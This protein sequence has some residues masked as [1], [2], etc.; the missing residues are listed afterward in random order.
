[1]KL[2]LVMLIALGLAAAVEADEIDEL[3][4]AD[5]RG[6][7][8]VSNTSGDVN[9]K[10]WNRDEIRVS[11]TLADG[12]ER[13]LAVFNQ[14]ARKHKNDCF[15]VVLGPLSFP[16]TRCN[17]EEAGFGMFWKMVSDQPVR[18]LISADEDKVVLTT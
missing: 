2:S 17:L 10:G 14:L 9:V 1:M 5:P 12:A 15:G 3:A 11:G 7:V 18:Y 4:D 8:E 13:L 6:R 16:A